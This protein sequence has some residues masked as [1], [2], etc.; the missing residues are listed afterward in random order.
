MRHS[1]YFRNFL[2]TSVVFL[3]SL[4]VMGCMFF[5]WSRSMVMRERRKSMSAATHEAVRY[6]S[7]QSPY[8]NYDLGAFEIRMSLTVISGISGFDI[9][10]T[11][12]DGLIV[13]CSDERFDSPYIGK[14]VPRDVVASVSGG[15]APAFIIALGDIYGERRYVSGVPLVMD[16][17]FGKYI[18]GYMFLSSDADSMVEIWRQFV[19]V[20][21][22]IAGII[23]VLTFSSSL[24]MS[25]KLSAPIN[26][27]ALAASRFARGDFT[28]RVKEAARSD[29]MGQLMRSFNAMA[30]SIERSENLRREFVA[31]V[32][33]ELKTPMTVIS[34]FADSILDG[35]APPENE[36]KYLE[37]ISSE[38]RRLSR[39]VRGML[40][41]SQLRAQ[42][43]AQLLSGSF[44]VSE[45]IR[46][47]ILGLYAKI[48]GRELE[49]RAELPE[50]P[51]VVRG[52]K[53]SITQVV[54]NLLDNAIKFA[55]VGSCVKVSL[56]RQ[57]ARVF[58]A[59]ENSGEAIP[60]DEMPMI[61]DRFHKTDHSRSA[62]RD[63]VGL[64]LYI[65]KAI[66]DNH[67]ED[68]FVTSG[69]GV[70]RFVFTLTSSPRGTA[71]G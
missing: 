40:D 53:D 68:I 12:E 46:V 25:K 22:M 66:L 49:A 21:A 50:E 65:V 3:I 39:L 38:T 2:A 67:N 62:N 54:Y 45:V 35:T 41:M 63:G 20:F 27:M 9:L 43:R 13:S 51:V 70:T 58:V 6:I 71:E 10:L 32:S 1:T 36:K 28:V 14:T 55:R 18:F 69:D 19:G 29:E 47:T 8:F 37:I 34:G 59:V 5:M 48:E 64:G 7:A 31:N 17:A 15:G 33:H 56:W 61:F 23:M 11:D 57:G 4:F 42:D 24:V 52:D 16:N 44:D 30:D 60:E 26:A